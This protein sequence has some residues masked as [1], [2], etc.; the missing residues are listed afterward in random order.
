DTTKKSL[1]IVLIVIIVIG[2]LGGLEA[3]NY[4][5]HIF[6]QGG[7]G[8]ATCISYLRGNCVNSAT[9]DPS[10]KDLT[11]YGLGQ[12]TQSTWYNVAFAYAPAVARENSQNGPVGAVFATSSSLSGNTLNSGQT[13]TFTFEAIN[14]SAPVDS[15][16]YNG[17]LWAAYTPSS[18]GSPC[19]G[20]I[21]SL[22]QCSFFDL[23]T[24][25]LNATS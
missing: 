14:A 9:Y 13:L 20:P 21:A 19:S 6:R 24:I 17:M 7:N 23:A 18:G 8:T 11:V 22:S 4:E 10:T 2:G 1:V 25:N 15:N 16:G 12:L 5:F 3:V